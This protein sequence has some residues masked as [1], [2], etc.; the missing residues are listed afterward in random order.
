VS[1]LS[2]KSHENITNNQET[3]KIQTVTIA[4]KEAI[5]NAFDSLTRAALNENVI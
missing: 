5:S 1:T 4:N 3:Q 2:N